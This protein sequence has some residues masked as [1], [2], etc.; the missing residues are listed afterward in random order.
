MKNSVTGLREC[1]LSILNLFNH[2]ETRMLIM[3]YEMTKSKFFSAFKFTYNSFSFSEER[4]TLM[5]SENVAGT[6]RGWNF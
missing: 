2:G 3:K 4:L 1:N 5:P 6:H